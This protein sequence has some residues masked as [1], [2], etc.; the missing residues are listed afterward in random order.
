MGLVK[1]RRLPGPRIESPAE[2]MT[3]ATGCPMERSIAQA[4]AHLIL[5]LE[6]EHG[7]DRWKAYDLLTHVGQ[8]SVGDTA[9][10]DLVT[11]EKVQGTV[12]FVASR[13]DT[14]TRTFRVEVEL[15]N[16]DNKLRD[17]V[18][19]DI[20]I[21]VKKVKAT[22]ISPGILVLDGQWLDQ[23]YVEPTMTR[24]GIGAG[25]V[26]LAKRQRPDGLRLW[27]FASNTGAQRFYERHGFIETERT[28]GG[29]NEE[30][31]PDVLYV[32]GGHTAEA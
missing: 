27:T 4:Y 8:I 2:L 6:A 23:L 3:V 25:L 20:H 22:H 24:R 9:M 21:P 5:W 16:P 15:P 7:W 10:A 13:A 29:A 31:A 11:G 1:G 26:E 18:S 28:D 30:G 17:G 19:A 14:T 32:W 12:R